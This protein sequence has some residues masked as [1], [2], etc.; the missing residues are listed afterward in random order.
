MDPLAAEDEGDCR[1]G[2][3]GEGESRAAVGWGWQLAR[4]V[5][6]A[7]EARGWSPKGHGGMGDGGLNSA[8][9]T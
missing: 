9:V 8:V 2:K 3:K 4:R 1:A 6:E 5:L 7:R